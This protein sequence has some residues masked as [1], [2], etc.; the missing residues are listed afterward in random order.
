MLGRDIFVFYLP[1]APDDFSNNGESGDE[2][3]GLQRS[4][5]ERHDSVGC[6]CRCDYSRD[7]PSER[8]S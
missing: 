6:R 1:L 8:T 5:R 3:I 7:R 2:P 4:R